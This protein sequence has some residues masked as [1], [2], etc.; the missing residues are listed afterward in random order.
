MFALTDWT[1][2]NNFTVWTQ[3]NSNEEALKTGGRKQ[4]LEN[5]KAHFRDGFK[6]RFVRAF[7]PVFSLRVY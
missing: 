3:K 5:F 4:I 1:G 2:A 6:R 7:Y